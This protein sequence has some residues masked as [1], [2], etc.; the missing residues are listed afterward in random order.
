MFANRRI[1]VA[2]VSGMV[3]AGVLAARPVSASPRGTAFRAG[4]TVAANIQGARLMLGRETLT[5]LA[6]GQKFKV[7][8]IQGNW[9]EGTVEV[10]GK[11][12]TGWV[13]A[14]QVTLRERDGRA[15]AQRESTRRYSYEPSQQ[16]V[17]SR[18]RRGYDRSIPNYTRQKTDPLR[19]Q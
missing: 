1:V 13:W 6:K 14:E 12:I 16:R 7:E 4:D 17:Y 11:P 9:V 15:I 2:T 8:K 18:Y 10:G 5:A 19:F 3:F